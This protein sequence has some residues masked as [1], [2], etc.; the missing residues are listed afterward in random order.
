MSILDPDPRTG[1]TGGAAVPAQRRR[2]RLLLARPARELLLEAA[3]R[4]YPHEACGV[5]AG[6]T[7]GARTLAWSAE[8]LRNAHPARTRDRYRLDAGEE[9]AAWERARALGFE[10]VGIWHSHP[11][12]PARPSETDRAAAWEG[13][14]YAI[15][16][17]SAEG[18]RELRSW[19]LSA[20][21]FH[22]EELSVMANVIFRIPTPLRPDAGGAA[23]LEL[24]GGTLAEALADLRAR[25]AGLHRRILD[26]EGRMR[27]FVKLF[28]GTR[29]AGE[30]Q[31][32]DTEL[33]EGAVVSILPAVAGGAR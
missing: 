15:A 20:G 26:E 9:L 14:S 17:V 8:E 31:G 4:R 2:G 1:D 10:L 24:Q 33:E 28:I 22:E 6:I 12:H 25:H 18:V 30:L 3:A 11:D 16:S 5:L 23:A 27:P 32:L 29:E 19:R 21:A 13:W 7:D